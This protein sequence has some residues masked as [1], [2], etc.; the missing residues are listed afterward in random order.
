MNIGQVMGSNLYFCSW[1]ETYHV[2]F[3]YD[4]V[5]CEDCQFELESTIVTAHHF[6]LDAVIMRVTV[7][8]KTH[9]LIITG[10]IICILMSV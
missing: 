7:V 10:S 5:C 4:C 1:R 8:E 2:L 9:T 3:N 6:L